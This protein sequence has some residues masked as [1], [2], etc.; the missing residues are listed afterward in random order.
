MVENMKTK[1]IALMVAVAGLLAFSMPV[2]AHHG[3]AAYDMQITRTLTGTITNFMMANP[4]TQIGLEVKDESGAVVPWVIEDAGT[5]RAMREGGWE[6]D[7][8]KPGDVVTITYH[9][10]KGPGHAGIMM[11]CVLPDGRVLPK[12]RANTSGGN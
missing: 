1:S 7:T 3:Y 5:V 2:L 6:F 8:L 9:P 12:P 11:K 4:H 10:A